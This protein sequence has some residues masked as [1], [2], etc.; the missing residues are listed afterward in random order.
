[1]SFIDAHVLFHMGSDPSVQTATSQALLADF[2]VGSLDL[3]ITDEIYIEINRQSDEQQ[4][5]LSRQLAHTFRSIEY[6]RDLAEEYEKV[7]RTILPA[8]RPSDI[9]DIRQIAK[10]ASSEA[11]VFVTADDGILRKASQI[12]DITDTRIVSPVSLVLEFHERL[13]APVYSLSPISGQSLFL[14]RLTANDLSEV[15]KVFSEDGEKRG[16][17]RQSIQRYLSRPTLYECNIIMSSDQYLALIV[18]SESNIGTLT[19]PLARVPQSASSRYPIEQFLIADLMSTAVSRGLMAVQFEAKGPGVRLVHHL[20]EMGF[21]DSNGYYVRPC[22]SGVL[23][24]DDLL[25]KVKGLFPQLFDRYSR[26]SN[27]ELSDRCSP[28]QVHDHD[29]IYVTIPIRPGYAL[30]LINRRA[31]GEDLFGGKSDVLMRWSNVYYRSK[32]HTNTLVPP[33]RIFWYESGKVG[34]ITAMSRLDSVETSDPKTLFRKYKRFG[35]LDWMDVFRLCDGD[36][37][38]EIMALKFSQTFPFRQPVPLNTLRTIEDRHNV[39][40]QSPRVVPIEVARQIYRA[41]FRNE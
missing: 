14:R 15:E 4:R 19:V 41:G 3:C 13:E 32:T 11:E 29:E 21:I 10:T 40:L 30:S 33:A 18:Q 20:F 36:P 39:P 23:N 1:M 7:L 5:R 22:I 38:R 26:F 8:R 34:A 31:A 16:V 28:V 17:F 9:S 2:L 12:E 6:D 25:N 24:R 35:T 37:D 27:Q